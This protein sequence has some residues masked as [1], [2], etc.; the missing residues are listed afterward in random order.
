MVTEP[1]LW[2]RLEQEWCP[3][4]S[5]FYVPCRHGKELD[6]LLFGVADVEAA[7]QELL[8]NGTTVAVDPAHSRN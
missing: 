2:E 8:R 3:T 5:R 4:G 6:R 7:F 1:G